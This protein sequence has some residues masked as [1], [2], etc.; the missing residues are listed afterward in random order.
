MSELQLIV[1][2]SALAVVMGVYGWSRWQEGRKRSTARRPLAPDRDP[3]FEPMVG[4]DEDK[5]GVDVD[6]VEERAASGSA[7]VRLPAMAPSVVVE[8]EVVL[9]G[10]VTGRQ[11]WEAAVH[12]NQTGVRWIAEIEPGQWVELGLQ[13]DHPFQH[14]HGLMQLAS[15]S[16]KVSD[17][18][19]ET[20]IQDARQL[21][22]RLGL[23]AKVPDLPVVSQAAIKLDRLSEQVDIIVGVNLV[24]SQAK[25]LLAA[26]LLEYLGEEGMT[27]GDDG[28]CHFRGSGERDRFTLTRRDGATFIPLTLDHDWVSAVTWLLEVARTENPVL[29]FQEMFAMAERTALMLQGQ[30][31]DDQGERL[32]VGQCSAIE[33]QLNKVAGL[34][35]AAQIPAGSPWAA[36]LFS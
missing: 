17:E 32:G 35:E 28:I 2:A 14:I 1:G 21:G 3:L 13:D 10:T 7:V 36:R 30:V 27:L 11:F 22:A 18:R 12:A 29:A 5:P 16:G 31:V 34:M 20:F 8:A 26:R 24:F 23:E 33:K 9:E 4:R 6:D 25:P 15:R 19:L